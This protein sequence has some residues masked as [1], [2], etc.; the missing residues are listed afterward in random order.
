MTEVRSFPAS[1]IITLHHLARWSA[2]MFWSSQSS[3]KH[4]SQM[5]KAQFMALVGDFVECG[6]G[7]LLVA[8]AHDNQCDVIC[9]AQ[10]C[11]PCSTRRSD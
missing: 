11:D 7:S 5:S 6:L 9:I 10:H 4:S 1:P 8:G 3:S 2:M